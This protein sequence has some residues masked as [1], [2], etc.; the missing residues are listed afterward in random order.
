M[1]DLVKK[2]M[3]FLGRVFFGP[4]F[5]IC[6]GFQFNSTLSFFVGRWELRYVP[7]GKEF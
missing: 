4:V 3:G 2:E 5:V 6:V 1:G 7:Q